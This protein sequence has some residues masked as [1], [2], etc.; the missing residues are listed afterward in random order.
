MSYRLKI[1]KKI[2]EKLSLKY[3][4]YTDLKVMMR[5]KYD[6]RIYENK[7]K[8]NFDKMASDNGTFFMED[9]KFKKAYESSKKIAQWDRDCYWRVYINC[10]AANH[11]KLIEG[12]FV[13]CGTHQG[14]FANAIIKYLDKDFKNLDKNFYLF[15]TFNGIQK[16]LLSEQEKQSS[17]GY[18]LG[19]YPE[20]YE[21]VKKRFSYY[22]NV[23][24]VRGVIPQSLNN[25]KIDKISYLSIDM[26]CTLP[27]KEALKHFWDKISIGG[28]IIFDD[29]GF[30]GYEEQRRAHDIFA[31][32]KNC[33]ICTL[34]TG[35]GLLIKNL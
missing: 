10:W 35:Q 26:N 19:H 16:N 25:V 12:D 5:N 21:E 2:A 8:Y 11:A 27:E 22:K 6:V 30:D 29:Y 7:W 23:H 20:C 1:L 28:I 17:S 33:E 18:L 31:K 34:P 32:S 3:L 24:L 15:D 14:G 9:T 4:E 13:E